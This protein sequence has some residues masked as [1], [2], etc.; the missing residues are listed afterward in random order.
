[1]SRPRPCPCGAPLSYDDHCGPL[2]RGEATAASAEDL[3]RSRYSAFVL[4]DVAYLQATWHP[5]TRPKRLDLDPRVRWTGL[6]IVFAH[7]GPF[8]TKGTVEFRA[9]H[10]HGVQHERSEFLRQDGRWYYLA[11]VT[12]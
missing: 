10:E 11:G 6:E 5:S 1:M 2:H 7:G 8:D 4:G 3:M 9:G 12:G